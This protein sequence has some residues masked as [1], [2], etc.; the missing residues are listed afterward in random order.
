MA[1][2]AAISPDRERELELELAPSPPGGPAETATISSTPLSSTRSP[3]P[4]SSISPP[5]SAQPAAPLSPSPHRIPYRVTVSTEFVRVLRT[6]PDLLYGI[7][8][9]WLLG[10]AIYAFLGRL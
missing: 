10:L 3:S 9:S 5:P 1:E 7:L 8:T 2:E 4:L 6:R